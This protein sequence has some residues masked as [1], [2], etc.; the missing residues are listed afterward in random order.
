MLL[1]PQPRLL[2]LTSPFQGGR[3]AQQRGGGFGARA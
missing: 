2:Q 1:P 3:A